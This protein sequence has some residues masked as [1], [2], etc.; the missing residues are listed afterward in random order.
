M[1]KS[2]E[3]YATTEPFVRAFSAEFTAIWGGTPFEDEIDSLAY[4]RAMTCWLASTYY[5]LESRRAYMYKYLESNFSSTKNDDTINELYRLIPIEQSITRIL[6]NLCILYNREPKREFKSTSADKY[7]E[8]Y[9]KGRVNSAL[10]QAHEF[11]RF[12]NNALIMPRVR[13]GKL[14]IDVLLPDLYRVITDDNNYRE[15]KELWIPIITRG[16]TDFHVWTAEEYRR[17]DYKGDTIKQEANRYGCIP[18]V[19]LQFNRN[20]ADYYGSGLF[21]LVMA[22]LDNNKLKFLAD[23]NVDYTGFSV[24]VATNF[25]VALDT[26][27]APNRLL[28]VDNIASGE[29]ALIEPDLRA[30]SPESNYLSI[31]ELRDMR[32]RRAL[33]D[34]GLPASMYDSNP[35]LAASGTAMLIERQELM[36]SREIDIDVMRHCEQE[37]CDMITKV[38]NADLGES[39]IPAEMGVDYA[40]FEVVSEPKYE[41]ELARQKFE[42]GLITALDF[43]KKMSGYDLASTNDDAIKYLK[44]NRDLLKLLES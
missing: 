37:L 7:K 24:W 36:E 43:V 27:I 33:R 4:F 2:T 39:L 6:R 10:R 30:I 15:V 5:D 34:C 13:A 35:G 25:G 9:A 28:R 18:G 16:T 21:E 29:G 22:T 20:T 23:N 1:T 14:D 26:R 41:F 31:E 44:N 32:Y 17:L 12:T 19:F 3:S 11:A 42:Y 38:V 40:E 8:N